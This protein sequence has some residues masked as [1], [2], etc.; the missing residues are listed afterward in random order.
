MEFHGKANLPN[1]VY[2]THGVYIHNFT[3]SPQWYEIYVQ[4][5]VIGT[6]P[7]HIED[8]THVELNPGAD[9]IKTYSIFVT[10]QE[11]KGIYPSNAETRV[12]GIEGA[13]STDKSLVHLE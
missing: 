1:Q 10:V 8:K 5:Y 11:P 3:D 2:S 13:Q 6:G 9:Y 7:H 12:S 4:L